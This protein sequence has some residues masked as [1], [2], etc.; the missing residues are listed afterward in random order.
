MCDVS[1]IHCTY[2][3]LCVMFQM[4]ALSVVNAIMAEDR[5]QQ[6]LSYLVAK[7]YLQHL[8]DSLPADNSGLHAALLPAP[9]QLRPL[10]IFQTKMVSGR[11]VCWVGGGMCTVGT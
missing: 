3:S 1:G 4:L 5:Y 7:G 9:S 6:W 2:F 8:V 11:F 10:Y